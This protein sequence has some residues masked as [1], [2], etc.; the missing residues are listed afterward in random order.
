M[1]GDRPESF[2]QAAIELTSLLKVG[3]VQG[4]AANGFVQQDIIGIDLEF[5]CI[6][7]RQRDR[8]QLI[9]VY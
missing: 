1:F 5:G 6:R 3:H 8:T 7:S 4:I 2:A 9:N